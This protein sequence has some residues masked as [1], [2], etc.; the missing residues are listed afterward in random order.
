MK[1]FAIKKHCENKFMDFQ[2]I[3]TNDQIAD[4]LTKSLPRD[5]FQQFCDLLD[6]PPFHEN[7]WKRKDLHS[8]QNVFG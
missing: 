6:L 2:Y 3:H 1:Y 8:L 5:T 4:I 7:E